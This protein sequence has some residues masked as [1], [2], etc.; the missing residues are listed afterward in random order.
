MHLLTFVNLL[1]CVVGAIVQSDDNSKINDTLIEVANLQELN[2]K[3]QKEFNSERGHGVFYLEEENIFMVRLDEQQDLELDLEL[4]EKHKRGIFSNDKK[5]PK[6]EWIQLNITDR[7]QMEYPGYIPVT[8]CQSVKYGYEG[9][10]AFE[11]SLSNLVGST[12]GYNYELTRETGWRDILHKDAT[13]AN[14]A[15]TVE[16]GE[17]VGGKTACAI[18]A[19]QTAQVMMKPMYHVVEPATRRARWS[20]PLKNWI[21]DED[22]TR[23][24]PLYTLIERNHYQTDCVTDDIVPLFCDAKLGEPK[25]DAPL[26]AD[27]DLK[28]IVHMETRL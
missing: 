10:V 19:N 13:S 20:A 3:Y 6:V 5:K 25:W 17:N 26:G 23:Y 1:T 14:I 4:D 11:Y 16:A 27:Y 12:I 18:K 15:L 2:K 24:E 21:I 7:Y 9:E 22:Y 28:F 8:E